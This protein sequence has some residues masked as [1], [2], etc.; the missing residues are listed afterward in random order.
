M[1]ARHGILEKPL[2]TLDAACRIHCL[3]NVDI[4]GLSLVAQLVKNLPAI[5]RDRWDVGSIPGWER[6]PG[7]GN[8]NLLKYSCLENSMDWGAWWATIHRLGSKRVWHDWACV[9]MYTH[10]HI[11]THTDAYEMELPLLLLSCFSHVRLCATPEMAA[12]QAPPSLGF[13]R[14]EHWSGFAISFSTAWK[15]KVKVK[16]LSCVRLLDT[17]WTAAYQAPL[18]IGFSRQECWSGV[19]LPSQRKWII[20]MLFRCPWSSMNS[21]ENVPV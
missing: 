1:L 14:Q 11:H 19:P 16:S 9:H 6:S 21:C 4:T 15:W 3:L 8:G 7:G 5:A 13:S 2:W 18:S 10:T 20:Y 12:H 17:P